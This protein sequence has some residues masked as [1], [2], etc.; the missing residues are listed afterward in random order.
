MA[1]CKVTSEPDR[2]RMHCLNVFVREILRGKSI[3]RRI[4]VAHFADSSGVDSRLIEGIL[5]IETNRR[6]GWVRWIERILLLLNA[7]AF[8]ALALPIRNFSIGIFQVGVHN[9]A[10]LDRI[11]VPE[12]R[13]GMACRFRVARIFLRASEDE[14]NARLACLYVRQLVDS[15]PPHSEAEHLILVGNTYNGGTGG[16]D[17]IS[18]GEVLNALVLR[19]IPA[20]PTTLSNQE[21]QC[22]PNT[23]PPPRSTGAATART[24]TF[25]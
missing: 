5:L 16:R 14:E 13:D 25:Y 20:E 3:L 1:G 6:P 15:L 8:V 10:L 11:G 24:P 22:T 4:D 2:Y 7:T 21:T 9:V 12:R 23:S 19:L 18:Y 17:A